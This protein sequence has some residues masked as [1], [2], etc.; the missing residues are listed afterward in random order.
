MLTN[1]LCKFVFLDALTAEL[2]SKIVPADKVEEESLKIAE[3]ICNLSKPVIG[4]G[5]TF[6]YAQTETDRNTAY[7]YIITVRFCT[8]LEWFLDWENVLWLKIWDYP[9]AK[10][11]YKDFCR[12]DIQNGLIKR[13][14]H[15]ENLL[16]SS[17]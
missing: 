3:K 4:L 7:R 6:F 10:K 12:S 15:I 9:I 1:I 5:K 2:V 8:F 16:Y 17:K 13:T 11:V 14:K